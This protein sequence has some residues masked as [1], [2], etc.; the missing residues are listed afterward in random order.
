MSL[1]FVIITLATTIVFQAA[2]AIWLGAGVGLLGGRRDSRLRGRLLKYGASQ[3]AAQATG[4][5]NT[6]LDKILLSQIAPPGV[7]GVYAV[8]ATLSSLANPIVQ[9]IGSV[10]LPRLAAQRSGPS[11]GV[12]RI[13]RGKL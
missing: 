8:A 5:V 1:R 2:I 12:V 3:W 13:H 4:E 10:M 6:S 11:A 9:A 7:L